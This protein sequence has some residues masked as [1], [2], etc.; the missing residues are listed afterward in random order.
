[1]MLLDSSE[2]I[3]ES[4]CT[5]VSGKDLCFVWQILGC[6]PAPT[7]HTLLKNNMRV[8]ELL[9]KIYLFNVRSKSQ[10]TDFMQ[11]AADTLQWQVG[12]IWLMISDLISMHAW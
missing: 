2:N 5:F 3:L 6:L 4:S 9:F 1:M 12:T 8:T 11:G 7:H 10:E